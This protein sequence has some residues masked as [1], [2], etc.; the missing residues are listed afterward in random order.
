MLNLDV[1]SD[2]REKGIIVTYLGTFIILYSFKRLL[3]YHQSSYSPSH[4]QEDCTRDI[5]N[6]QEISHLFPYFS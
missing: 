3:L 5:T 4:K 6:F 1:I 2:A